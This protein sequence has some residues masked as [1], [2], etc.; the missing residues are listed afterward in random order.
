MRFTKRIAGLVAGVGLLTGTVVGTAAPAQAYGALTIKYAIVDTS[1]CHRIAGTLPV[2]TFD[3]GC[4]LYDS[5]DDTFFKKQ[6]GGRAVKIELYNGSAMVAKVEFHPLGDELWVYD[7]SNDGDS[8]YVDL[9]WRDAI[10]GPVSPPGTDAVVE[11]KKEPYTWFAE[12]DA[13]HPLGDQVTLHIFDSVD[14]YGVP[15]DQIGTVW[16][17]NA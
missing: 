4:Q 11:Y 9:H 15:Y 2:H 7:T 10:Y 14:K 3:A 13:N 17:G 1:N 5:A 8:I 6:D 16:S 12:K